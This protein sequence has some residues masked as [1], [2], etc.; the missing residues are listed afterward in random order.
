[1][2]VFRLVGTELSWRLDGKL[3]KNSNDPQPKI[4]CLMTLANLTMKIAS[5]SK[6]RWIVD[7][8]STFSFPR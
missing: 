1:M 8:L 3:P 6:S 4:F 7:P 2:K 5:D